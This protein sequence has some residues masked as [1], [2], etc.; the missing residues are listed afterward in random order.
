MAEIIRLREV[1]WGPIADHDINRLASRQPD[2]E[3]AAIERARLLTRQNGMEPLIQRYQ[4]MLTLVRWLLVF[5]MI[6]SGIVLA[7][8]LTPQRNPVISVA[9]MLIGLL[10]VNTV[11]ILLWLIMTV[12]RPSGGGIGNTLLHLI[13]RRFMAAD[14]VSVV[15]AYISLARRKQLLQPAL[16]S[17]SHLVWFIMLS[18]ALLTLTLRFI[19]YDYQ[20]VWRTTLLSEDHLAALVSWLQVVPGWF[21]I[22]EPQ[23][24]LQADSGHDADRSTALWLL[25]CLLIYAIIPRLLL[26][27]VC[28]AQYKYRLSRLSM[29]WTLPGFAELKSRLATSIF[30]APTDNPAGVPPEI[31]VIPPR[32]PLPDKVTSAQSGWLCLEGSLPEHFSETQ[33]SKAG[34]NY[35][36]IQSRQQR[37]ALLDTLLE[38]APKRLLVFINPQLSADRGSLRFLAQLGYYTELSVFIADTLDTPKAQYWREQIEEHL[39]ATILTS[40]Q[41]VTQWLQNPVNE[42]FRHD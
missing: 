3:S 37:S 4:T 26:G 1:H 11:F 27:L 13:Q 18:S 14:Q 10:M 16:S 35:G 9:D 39:Q 36:L 40:P 38:Q 32:R 42:G 29:D 34:V 15:Q 7:V 12:V 21:G 28:Y 22:A 17:I 41:Q 20:F 25:S 30:E 5:L 33:L 2:P 19:G 6:G 24:A 31:E 8:S 23:I